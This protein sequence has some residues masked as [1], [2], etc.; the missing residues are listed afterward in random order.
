MK[1]G[2]QHVDFPAHIH[3]HCLD[4]F[5]TRIACD[6][7]KTV[8]PSDGQSDHMTVIAN[9]G[10]NL[11][12]YPIKKYFSFRRVKGIPLTDF[13]S[14]IKLF[15]SISHLKLTCSKLYQQYLTVLIS[16]L[17]KYAPIKTI[18]PKPPISMDNNGNSIC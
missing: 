15:A 5:I 10:G 4:L 1:F 11:L 6:L 17:D 12:S 16:L 14:D 9:V 18:T 2:S 7:I 3:G 8:Y 13:I